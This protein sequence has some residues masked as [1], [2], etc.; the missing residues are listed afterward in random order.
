MVLFNSKAGLDSPLIDFKGP[1]W[2]TVIQYPPKPRN[3]PPFRVIK[4]S[5]NT[6]NVSQMTNRAEQLIEALAN[7]IMSSTEAAAE[8]LD[9]AARVAQIQQRMAA[10]GAVLESVGAQKEALQSRLENKSIPSSQR[11]LI[12]QQIQM[13]TAQETEILRRAGAS[14]EL[15]RN[16]IASADG[17]DDDGADA[18]PRK[19]HRDGRRFVA[20]GEEAAPSSS[21]NPA[22][23]K[24][25]EK[26]ER[27]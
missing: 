6:S 9:L 25:K 2:S 14:T 16:A 20:I 17:G 13:L 18:D 8:R 27:K 22:T 19:Y 1:N 26:P 15:A 4:T 24:R 5:M 10:F 7:A 12:E 11:Q 3:T 21:P 23:G